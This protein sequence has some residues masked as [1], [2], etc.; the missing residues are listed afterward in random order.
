MEI[1]VR[2]KI[3]DTYTERRLSLF[4]DEEIELNRVWNEQQILS[5]YG[6]WSKSF[7]VPADHNNSEIF[8]YYNIIGGVL[9]NNTNTSLSEQA[10]PNKFMPAR[11]VINE[12]EIIGNLQLL[13]FSQK[14]MSNFSFNIIFY[15][16]EKN[17]ISYLN[18]STTP[19]LKDI[20]FDDVSFF[21]NIENVVNSWSGINSLYFVPTMA[22]SRAINYRD[23]VEVGN[24]NSSVMPATSGL[25][26]RDLSVAYNF[27]QILNKM[28][29]S[30]GIGLSGSTK[31]ELL[32]K[33]LYMMPNTKVE[34]TSDLTY[35]YTKAFEYY[36]RFNGIDC[37]I[38]KLTPNTT[39]TTGIMPGNKDFVSYDQIN[40]YVNS[41]NY[42]NVQST[43]QYKF[44]FSFT[45]T[46][47][48]LG[49]SQW[50]NLLIIDYDSNVVL[51]QY[52]HALPDTIEIILNL[53]SGQT[54]QFLTYYQYSVTDYDD[55]YGTQYSYTTYTDTNYLDDQ[56][57]ALI[58]VSL[59]SD[60]P[61]NYEKSIINFPDMYV[62]DFLIN[63]C[64]TFNI[65]FIYDDTSDVG[66]NPYN[67]VGE[68]T[69][70]APGDLIQTY[71][72]TNNVV[73]YNG[74][75]Y[76]CVNN[77]QSHQ[78]TPPPNSNFTLTDAYILEPYPT[79]GHVKLYFKDELTSNTYDLSKYL[80]L[81]KEYTYNHQ[82]KFKMIDY[83]FKEGK[84]IS[85]L[86]WF[87]SGPTSLQYGESKI[88]YDYDFGIDKLE[89]TSMFTIFPRTTLN[90]TDDQNEIIENTEICF[91][92]ELNESLSALN[93]DFLLMY[94]LPII[95]G[96]THTY[97]LQNSST[98]YTE[99]TYCS[100]Y[101][102]DG[103]N[104]Y[105]LD[106]TKLTGVIKDNVNM[107]YEVELD[108]LLPSEIL[109]NIKIYDN[110]LINNIYYDILEMTMNIRNGLTSIKLVTTTAAFT[111]SKLEIINKSF[112]IGTGFFS[113]GSTD[114]VVQSDGKIV[115]IGNFISYS[116]STYNKIIRLNTNGT[117]DTSFVIGTGF[118]TGSTNT[119]LSIIN[120]P[121]DKILV[122]G[123]FTSYSGVTCNGIVRL[124][125]DGS[126]DSGFTSNI[127]TSGIIS[128]LELQSD[129]KILV[130]G[131]LN[132]GTTF[133]GIVRLNSDGTTDNSYI[134]GTPFDAIIQTMKIQTD[135]KILVGGNFTTYSG[136][137]YNRLIRL[138]SD[139]TIDTSF[140][141]GTGFNQTIDSI[142]IQTDGKILVGG[143][144]TTYSGSTYNRIIRLNSNGAI[145]TS[146][147]IGNGFNGLL[148]DIVVQ[149]DG[150]ILVVGAFTSYNN[151]AYNRIIRLNS[152]GTID[153][154]FYVGSGFD[155]SVNNITLQSDGKIILNGNFTSYDGV[156][157][158]RIVRLNSDGTSDTIGVLNATTTT[159][160]T[161]ASPTTTTTTTT[162]VTTTTTT[163][164]PNYNYIARQYDCST[165]L[166][167]TGNVEIVANRSDLDANRYYDDTISGMKYRIVMPGG[168]G[169]ISTYLVGSG[170]AVCNGMCI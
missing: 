146:F 72:F 19:K 108:F 7:S 144:F 160:T 21:F 95:T 142:Y 28:L 125:V 46:G 31:V 13:S 12:Y 32:M 63:F 23:V 130:T 89:Y 126:I 29:L 149:T 48:L 27:K 90:K 80:L 35:I 100:D 3:K 54:I 84:D 161:T 148:S 159:T 128:T 98:G 85:N 36:T 42:Y 62:S 140:V 6:S 104:G 109:Y 50:A 86:A 156:L 41:D 17:L 150:K 93:T 114:S 165:C 26:M 116:G 151:I 129:G 38:L 66:V 76:V 1:Y 40:D 136:L 77:H 39:T 53:T 154:Y 133:T 153:Y 155:S 119:P 51:K 97:N 68:W 64:K 157:Y 5:G 169:T 101:S 52:A 44:N 82:K 61:Y 43:G 60:A 18:S 47:T 99:M 9:V 163:A 34:Y 167:L 141:I 168:S 81:D 162:P 135:G 139:G 14:N 73:T 166:S 115:V 107:K 67:F 102:P 124:N 134:V 88:N 24:I 49:E 123:F 33:D 69:A 113:T 70:S 2:F 147:V 56:L 152:D 137:T 164:A 78:S 10:N 11:I 103:A 111:S 145:D 74:N 117:I 132:S 121:D 8:K 4:D 118:G 112:N 15:G 37:N 138:N 87:R 105:S 91:H 122:G 120:Q 58:K 22:T 79:K 127:S 83:K 143:L 20:G 57:S 110:I 55:Q 96:L 94:R 59:N 170:L 106:Y 71:Y 92:S 75:Y 25:S 158:N 30:S 45:Q 65:F 131:S 16:T